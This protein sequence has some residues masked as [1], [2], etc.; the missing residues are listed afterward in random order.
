MY[1]QKEFED[2]KYIVDYSDNYVVLY[3]RSYVNGDYQSP[4][5]IKCLV[6]YNNDS[7][8][9]F[10]DNRTFYTYKTFEKINGTSSDIIDA[11]EF[12]N[13]VVLCFIFMCV[14]RTIGNVVTSVVKRGGIFNA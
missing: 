10:Y 8:L 2:Y 6:K 3:N 13:A 11:P 5:I 14:L 7:S 4:S 12:F 9:Y 1:L